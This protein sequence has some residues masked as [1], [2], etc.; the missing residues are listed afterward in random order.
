MGDSKFLPVVGEVVTDVESVTKLVGAGIAALVG[1]TKDAEKLVKTAG[2]PWVAYSEKNVIVGPISSGIRFP[3][4][5]EQGAE[6]VIKS[7]GGAH[8][9]ASSTARRGLI[10]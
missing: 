2:D 10:T 8:W 4:G 1:N 3:I 5:D 9:R 6:R 7:T